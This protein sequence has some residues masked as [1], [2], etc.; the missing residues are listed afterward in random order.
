M[1]SFCDLAIGSYSISH[2]LKTHKPGESTVLMAF[3]GEPLAARKTASPVVQ[4]SIKSEELRAVLLRPGEV[5]E[6]E[7]QATMCGLECCLR[8]GEGDGEKTWGR[9]VM[10]V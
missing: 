1:S 5:V 6:E 8:S 3:F 2:L 9:S 4:V 7:V 10:W